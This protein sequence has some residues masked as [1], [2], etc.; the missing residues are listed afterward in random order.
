[1]QA[2][3]RADTPSIA[4]F[5]AFA[6]NAGAP[7]FGA[8]VSFGAGLVKTFGGAP[9]FRDT[10]PSFVAVLDGE[11][12]AAETTVGSGAA[13]G[14]A[15]GDAG[16]TYSAERA[17]PVTRPVTAPSKKAMTM[18][19]PP[20]SIHARFGRVFQNVVRGRHSSETSIAGAP[21]E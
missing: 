17:G 16:A 4:A 19:L 1:L 10:F 7:C 8:G 20:T 21:V 13:A 14:A 6:L 3:R 18:A 11:A 9:V 2:F 5:A 12:G 15:T